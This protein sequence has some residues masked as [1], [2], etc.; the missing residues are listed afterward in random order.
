MEI[1]IGVLTNGRELSIQTER[2]IDDIEKSWADA[3]ANNQLFVIEGENGRRLVLSGQAVAY[4]DI[5][6]QH[7]RPVG[8]GLSHS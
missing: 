3:L 1:K 4:I 2:S 5:A 6:T 7:A 8:F